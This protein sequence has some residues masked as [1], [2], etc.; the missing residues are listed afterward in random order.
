MKTYVAPIQSTVA[1]KSGNLKIKEKI[2]PMLINTREG[3]AIPHKINMKITP[4]VIQK[5]ILFSQ[6][7]FF[8]RPEPQLRSFFLYLFLIRLSVKENLIFFSLSYCLLL[9]IKIN[10]P[11]FHNLINRGVNSKLHEGGNADLKA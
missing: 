11:L 9:Y 8:Y 5:F 4:I 10:Y 3:A 6:N 2:H 1:W 7:S